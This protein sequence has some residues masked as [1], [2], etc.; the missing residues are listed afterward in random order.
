MHVRDRFSGRTFSS[1]TDIRTGRETRGTWN[2]RQHEPETP[3]RTE[4]TLYQDQ[5]R[6]KPAL[7]STRMPACL[8]CWTPWWLWWRVGG[9]ECVTRDIVSQVVLPD[10][11]AVRTIRTRAQIPELTL[12]TA[13][14][15]RAPGQLSL[16][17]TRYPQSAS[18]IHASVNSAF[19]KE[20][21]Y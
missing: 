19:E 5:P 7:A 21:P 14:F 2:E 3:R 11:S 15:A 18:V 4:P 13:V 8:V 16:D 10:I 20:P 1:G 17:S 6:K 9:E 12:D